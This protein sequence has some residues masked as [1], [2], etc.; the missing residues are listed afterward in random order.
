MRRAAVGLILWAIAAAGC[1]PQAQTAAQTSDMGRT[2]NEKQDEA[3][4]A[5]RAYV[6]KQFPDFVE[7][8]KTP[9]VTDAGE[10][11][12]FTYELPADMLGGAPVVLLA[13]RDLSVVKSYRTQ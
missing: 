13:K 3:I 9:V 7:D 12:E 1:T 6:K 4:A 10:N 11:W 8:R 5:G 2:M